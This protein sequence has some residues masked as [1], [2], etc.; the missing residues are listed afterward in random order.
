M[1]NNACLFFSLFRKCV[2]VCITYIYIYVYVSDT[3]WAYDL[4]SSF[5][6]WTVLELWSVNNRMDFKTQSIKVYELLT[7]KLV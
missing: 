2:G 3:L 1:V 7:P 4:S 5:V 6:F